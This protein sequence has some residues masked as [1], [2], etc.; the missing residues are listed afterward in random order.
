VGLRRSSFVGV[1]LAAGYGPAGCSFDPAGDASDAA[2]PADV[3]G[4]DADLPAAPGPV[5]RWTFQDGMAIDASGNQHDGTVI[6]QP[7]VIASPLG[8]ALSFD[9]TGG[10]FVTI[11]RAGPALK[12]IDQVAVAAWLRLDSSKTFGEVLSMGDNYALRVGQNVEFFVRAPGSWG[13]WRV[14]EAAE[15]LRDGE[16]HHVVGQYTGEA[17]EIH[18][19]GAPAATLAFDQPIEYT[20]GEDLFVG[21]HSNS[22]ETPYNLDG[23]IDEVRVYGRPLEEAEIR[24]L[25]GDP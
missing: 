11:E 6:G 7:P 18:V 3:A 22:S 17:L 14:L 1:L 2:A 9:G 25:A 19:D 5:L 8:T 10:A 4:A 20:Q 12:P 16:W 23:D 15:D 13:G 21:R 24:A